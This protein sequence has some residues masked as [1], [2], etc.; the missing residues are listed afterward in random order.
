MKPTACTLSNRH[1][2][3]CLQPCFEHDYSHVT[4]PP[5]LILLWLHA[6]VCHGRALDTRLDK[7]LRCHTHYAS[8]HHAQLCPCIAITT[9]LQTAATTTAVAGAVGSATKTMAAMQKQMNPQKINQTMMAFQKVGAHT[10]LGGRQ[11][12][13]GKAWDAT[14]EQQL[15]GV[16][17]GWGLAQVLQWQEPTRARPPCVW[18]RMLAKRLCSAHASSKAE[19]CSK[20]LMHAPIMFV[21]AGKRQAGDGG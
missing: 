15:P 3:S 4:K 10:G 2:Q 12:Q 14:Q 9:H 17:T 19:P 5:W 8:N 13:L 20:W 1:L 7:N 18:L 16:A 11:A 21:N 6:L